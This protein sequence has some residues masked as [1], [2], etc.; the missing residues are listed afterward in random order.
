MTDGPFN[1]SKLGSRWKRFAEAVQ[2]DAVDM[3]SRCALASDA[4]LREI[5]TDETNALLANLRVYGR[6]QQ[7]DIDP[8]SLVEN[9]FNEHDK[10][11]F[12]DILQKQIAIR[13]GEQMPPDTAIDQAL[14][15]TV[16]K[17]ISEA[18]S[19]IE[20]ECIRARDTG[21]MQQDQFE[22][23]VRE[24]NAAFHLLAETEICDAVRIGDKDAFK[25]AVLKKRGTH[26][27]PKL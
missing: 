4:L 26:E 14:E 10:T 20:E 18:R 8:A 7:L 27:G 22:R 17:Q 13:L 16:G 2:N 25:D 23:T 15:A 1:N 12:A 5:L 9:I 6:Q 21:E 24:A 19:R 3:A 11:P